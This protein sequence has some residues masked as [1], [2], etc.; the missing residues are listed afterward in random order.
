MKKLIWLL[1]AAV[2]FMSCDKD[3]DDSTSN[4]SLNLTGLKDAGSNLVYEGWIIVGG[5]PVSTGRFTVNSTGQLSRTT[6]TV[7][8]TQLQ[9]ATM[10]ILTLEPQTDPDPAPSNMKIL[11]GDFNSN[12]ASVN[13]SHSSALGTNFNAAAGT[14]IL[15]TPTNGMGTNENSGVWFLNPAA[16]PGPS[17]TLPALP[18][19]WKYEGWAVINGTPVTTGK[20]V[21]PAGADQAAP[22]SG[23]MPGPPFPGEDFLMSAPTG[24]TFPTNLAGQMI[25]I[26][27][28]PHP[29]NSAMPFPLKPLGGMVPSN[30]TDHTSY[31]LNNTSME[32]P[33]GTVVKM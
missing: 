16:G 9:S 2:T 27:I 32:L 4:L 13:V 18:A 6:F 7:N 28:E 8:K 11:A 33:M 21:M 10:F 31:S 22:F 5:Q 12:T 1:I 26:T 3:D 14:Y 25:V 17:L 20:F 24:L 30:A 19:A 29:D 15:A 23:P